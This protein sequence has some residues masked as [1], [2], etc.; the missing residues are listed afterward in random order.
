MVRTRRSRYIESTV[1]QDVTVPT[2]VGQYLPNTARDAGNLF[3]RYVPDRALYVEAGAPHVGDQ[4]TNLPNTILL[5]GYDRFDAAAGYTLGNVSLT[6]AVSNLA[7]RIYWRSL[8]MPG[9]PRNVL[10]RASCQ[11]R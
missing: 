11:F 10:L 9:T 8:A 3:V 5:K 6:I 7:D 4:W 2:N 1:R